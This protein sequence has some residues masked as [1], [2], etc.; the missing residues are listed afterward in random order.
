MRRTFTDRVF[1][2]VGVQTGDGRLITPD[3]LSFPA[4]PQPLR[5]ASED[6]GMHLG[7]V[8]AGAIESWRVEAPDVLA[9]GWVDDEIPGG[10]A[11]VQLIDSGVPM[12]VSVD[13]DDVV[14]EIVDTWFDEHG[15]PLDNA[16]MAR[17]ALA[18]FDSYSFRLGASPLR[19]QMR[20]NAVTAA[21]GD[22][23][24]E[25]GDIWWV[26]ASDEVLERLVSARGRG[27][28]IVDM[29][30]FDRALMGLD[31][32]GASDDAGSTTETAVEPEPVA[33]SSAP[34]RPVTVRPVPTTATP[35]DPILVA[36]MRQSMTG[37]LLASAG[38][39]LDTIDPPRE[40]FEMPEPDEHTPLHVGDDGRVWGHVWS[41]GCH[42]ASQAGQCLR[43]PR[44]SP[45]LPWFHTGYT[46]TAE[47]HRIATGVMTIGGGHADE[48]LDAAPAREHYDNVATAWADVV[49][50][51]GRFGGWACGAARPGLTS[52]QLRAI[53]G[54]VPS[55]DW[56]G[57]GGGSELIALHQVNHPGYPVARF[58]RRGRPLAIVA[59]A[60]V[61][62]GGAPP[63]DLGS[64][65]YRRL[66]EQVTQLRAE[67]AA[68]ARRALRAAGTAR[69]RER[70]RQR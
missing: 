2:Q 58:D 4:G 62:A 34:P 12:G 23:D 17:S 27:A 60:T 9:S 68:P 15:E 6:W 57:V 36:E 20:P 31:A 10:A 44:S 51:E 64:I 43:A 24:V 56:R 5:L 28:T 65:A 33:A 16:R 1:A 46:V 38:I 11:A 53:R 59:A 22:P 39:G 52:A 48:T 14:V 50:V 41:G 49:V 63:D 3:A 70:L 42:S 35:A 19:A 45:G 47:G 61:T 37:T 66:S 29:P 54:S 25:D 21:A 30:A 18:R 7:A 8:T 67:V 13:L 40:W 55:G 26:F 32:A 69:A